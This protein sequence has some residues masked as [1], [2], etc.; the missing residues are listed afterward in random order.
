M[1]KLLIILLF[2]STAFG[3]F[4]IDEGIVKHY[5]DDGQRS[6]SMSPSDDPTTIDWKWPDALG[7][8]GQALKSD[9]TNTL[10]W[11]IGTPSSL[12]DGGILL[13]NGTGNI[14][15]LG[16]AANGEIPIGDGVTDPVLATITGSASVSVVN[17]P[18]SITLSALPAGIDHGGLAGLSDV[19]DHAYA[20]L[21]DGTRAMTGNIDMDDNDI[22][23]CGNITITDPTTQNYLI[24][25][26]ILVDPARPDDL[27]IQ[28]S[29]SGEPA[30]I[31]LFAQDLDG[32]D[33]AKFK[34]VGYSGSVDADDEHLLV[35]GWDTGNSCYEMQTFSST[36][37]PYPLV[38][39]TQAN[40]NQL[41]LETDGKVGVGRVPT[42]YELEVNT[43]IWAGDGVIANDWLSANLARGKSVGLRLY[44]HSDGADDF[45]GTIH[46]YKDDSETV[47]GFIYLNG[48]SQ[49]VFDSADQTTEFDTGLAWIDCIFGNA[50]FD[51]SVTV[52]EGHTA[53]TGLT[54]MGSGTGPNQRGGVIELQDNA[55]E[56]TAGFVYF[57]IF[58][59]VVF[60]DDAQATTVDAGKAWIDCDDGSVSFSFTNFTISSAGQT[61]IDADN[62][63]LM[64]GEG[65]TPG[66]F[67]DVSLYFDGSDMYINSENVTANDELLFTNFD[68]YDFDND[69]S[70]DG[71]VSYT[72]SATTNITAAGGITVTNVIMRI[73][74]DGGAIDITADPQIADGTDGQIV[75]LQFDSDA[76][77]VK[78]D[79]GTG[80]QLAGGVSFTGGK[81]DIWSGT[82]DSGDDLWIEL[83]RSDN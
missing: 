54:L 16:V 67:G 30:N 56:T 8:T 82:Y 13:G 11:G 79:D 1:K 3:F 63:K 18:G 52:N 43:D 50:G 46:L 48:S 22:I 59:Q 70:I 75:I 9:G 77:T 19:A 7:S 83:Y 34:T 51:G 17:G 35:F 28:S 74:G 20:F 80:L 31:T 21:H 29:L 61:H 64:L 65:V 72:P 4:E 5:S 62:A 60:D 2:A 42:A 24:G 71:I 73:Q 25:G 27:Q 38:L 49:I 66:Q 39:F 12:T 33:D 37:T 53:A 78:L 23:D 68:K 57:N 41:Y 10:D 26:D 58:H 40:T 36:G 81:G 15:A 55:T 44:G 14:V 45:G 69:V 32:T 76:N 47:N 6:W